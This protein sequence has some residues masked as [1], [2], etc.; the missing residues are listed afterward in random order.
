MATY[1]Q[2]IE[3]LEEYDFEKTEGSSNPEKWTRGDS[4]PYH[5]VVEIFR[6]EKEIYCSV[7]GQFYYDE[8]QHP[9]S[10]GAFIDLC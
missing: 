2:V 7:Y 8:S 1:K 10:Y 4:A 9:M 6:K 5:E 3:K